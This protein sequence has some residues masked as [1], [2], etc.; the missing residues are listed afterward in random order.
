MGMMEG[1]SS[2]PGE[3][4]AKTLEGK[5]YHVNCPY[6]HPNQW[7]CHEIVGCSKNPDN[8]GATPPATGTPPAASGN[9][10]SRRLTRQ[11]QLAAAL[12]EEGGDSGEEDEDL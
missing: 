1:H 6:H 5:C 4:T 10:G 11:A 9:S 7:V 3:A 2:R 12:L 8:T